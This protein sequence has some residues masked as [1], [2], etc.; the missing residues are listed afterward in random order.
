[1][2]FDSNDKID[3]SGKVVR[4]ESAGGF[5]FYEAEGKLYVAL[6]V[7]EDGKY[8]IPKGHLKNN[9]LPLKAAEREL[10]EELDIK[11]KLKLVGKLGISKYSFILDDNQ[12]HIKKVHLFVFVINQKMDKVNWVEYDKAIRNMA[13]DLKN[14]EK[15]KKILKDSLLAS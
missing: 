10:R 7:G 6:L 13:F 12:K 4:H 3:F 2:N 14:L 15:A 9:E 11:D 8:F 5:L 1:M